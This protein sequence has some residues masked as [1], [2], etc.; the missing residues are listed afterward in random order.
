MAARQGP[1]PGEEGAPDGAAALAYAAVIENRAKEVGLAVLDVPRLQLCVSQF[2]EAGRSYTT[3][4]LLLDA[5]APR[6]LVVVG[7]GHHEV[8]GAAGVNQLTA[9]AGWEQVA[10]PRSAFD[11]AKGILTVHEAAGEPGAQLG[12]GSAQHRSH[13]LG[14][15]AAGALLH[16]VRRSLGLALAPRALQVEF[17]GIRHHMAIDRDALASLEV[18]APSRARSAL[19]KAL[20]G[21][22]AGAAAAAL[23]RRAGAAAP[24]AHAAGALAGAQPAALPSTAP[25]RPLLGGGAAAAAGRRRGAGG[26][27]GAGGGPPSPLSGSLLGFLSHTATACGAR[28]LRT[29]LLQPLTDVATLEL[30]LDSVQELLE[31]PH[32]TLE[33]SALLETLPKDLDKVCS[34]LGLRPSGEGGGA[35]DPSARLG[36]LV[37]AVILLRDVL[38]CL[39][40]MADSMAWVDSDLLKARRGGAAAGGQEA[41]RQAATRAAAPPRRRAAAPPRRHDRR[42]APTSARLRSRRCCAT[43]RPCLAGLKVQY[44]ASKGFFLVVP[45]GGARTSAAA[46][47]AR[48]R[49]AGPEHGPPELPK[50]FLVLEKRGRGAACVTT[51]ELNALNRRLRDAAADC[52]MLT[53]S[54]LEGLV[55]RLLQHMPLLL[56]TLDNIALLDLL[57]AFFHAVAGSEG[58]FCR[59]LLSASGPLA[60]TKG[61]HPLLIVRLQLRARCGQPALTGAAPDWP[62]PR[63]RRV[64]AQAQPGGA[65]PNDVYVGPSCPLAV[66]AG[67]NMSGKSTLLKTAALLV[68]LAQVGCFVP[69]RFMALRRVPPARAPPYEAL[70]TRVG[71]AD[72]IEANA[73]SFV[74]EMADMAHLLARQ[75]EELAGIYPS[76]QLWRMQVSVDSDDIRY[77]WTVAPAAAAGGDAGGGA[78]GVHYGVLLARAAGLPDGVTR[79]ALEVAEALEAQAQRQRAAQQQSS[80]GAGGGGVL[81]QAY[82]LVHKLGCVARQAAAGGALAA[83]GGGGDAPGSDGG[84]G[85]AWPG[86]AGGGDADAGRAA[87]QR[88][89]PPLAALKA[90]AERLMALSDDVIR[91]MKAG[92][93]LK[94]N[95]AAI[96]SLDFHR[97]RD[98]LITASDDDSLHIYDTAEGRLLHTV[99]SHKYGARCVTWQHSSDHVVIASNKGDD[100]AL[101][102]LALAGVGRF[103]R[104]FRGHSARV[105]C[106]APNPSTDAFMSAAMVRRHPA[107]RVAE[108]AA[109]RRRAPRR[110]RAPAMRRAARRTPPRQDKEVRMWDAR[111]DQCVAALSAPCH[112]VVTYDE[113]GLVFALGLDCGVVKLYDARSYEQGPFE[114]F[115]VPELRNSPVPFTRLAFSNDGKLLLGVAEGRVLLLDAFNGALLRSFPNGV[116]DAGAA[117]EAS[118]SFDGQYVLSGCEDRNVR[119]WSVATGALVATWGGHAGVP[120]CCRWAP[121]RLLAASACGAVCLWVPGPD[122]L[123][124]YLAGG[125][126]TQAALQQQQQQAQPQVAHQQ[127]QQQAPPPPQ[128][129]QQQQHHQ[130]YQPQGGYQGGY[131]PA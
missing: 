51:H 69:A 127:A 56:R 5:A 74:V 58:E 62:P 40:A 46:A 27:G 68:L 11:D 126:L 125:G 77:A 55:A 8:A 54:V 35:R 14:F 87:L 39:P 78:G 90:Q 47:S 52:M 3:T 53:C 15:G 102:Y 109:P 75:L 21:S 97:S 37:S 94:D 130:Q 72:T 112:P 98:L 114:T 91:G 111:V 25:S 38:R 85:I 43:W 9:A 7:G 121:R 42:S 82:S 24:P 73:S 36:R 10:L 93:V 12:V 89:L 117:P 86:F 120:Y 123:K 17:D 105:T 67:P 16:H 83:G 70:H 32:L 92:R 116:G 31:S 99:G 6:Q 84:G 81:R 60:I 113:Q 1:P 59:P 28:L 124:S 96:N 95:S 110:R 65:Q 33:L 131:A 119:V 107:A 48:G 100:H 128:Q 103:E 20:A 26:G 34:N 66:V 19:L 108:R 18:L 61:R 23:Q 13:Y 88:C 2:V 71:S 106:A 49:A 118:L 129:Q 45:E 22:A 63:A 80:G 41:A 50:A 30:R 122:A 44:S 29:N 101:R 76:A 57:V 115:A 79:R 104:Y 4:Q 64:R